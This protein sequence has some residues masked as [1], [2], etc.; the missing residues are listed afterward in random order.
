MVRKNTGMNR[1]F[2]MNSNSCLA[3]LLRVA[4]FTA[5]PARKA[6]MIPSRWIASAATAATATSSSMRANC[7]SLGGLRANSF[8]ATH[9][10]PRI[11]AGT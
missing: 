8:W 3:S 1:W 10:S 6:P 5:R 11:T 4:V 2:P 7:P 9:P